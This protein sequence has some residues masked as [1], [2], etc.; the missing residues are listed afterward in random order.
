VIR[1]E[2]VDMHVR[3]S[4][5]DAIL[6]DV[7]AVQQ[8]VKARAHEL[9]RERGGEWGRALDDWLTAERECVWRPPVELSERDG[10]M[11]LEMAAAGVDGAQLDIRLTPQE[12]V[13]TAPMRHVHDDTKGTVHVCEFKRGSLFR[14]VRFPHP[15]DPS[16]ARAEFQNGLLR[17]SVPLAAPTARRV[18]VEIL[19]DAPVRSEVDC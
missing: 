19:R 18:E 5:L 3:E 11:M 10:S 7:D 13:I 17:L 8:K 15:V 6:Q 14:S 2:E 12:V 1:L 9:F 4:T 16:R